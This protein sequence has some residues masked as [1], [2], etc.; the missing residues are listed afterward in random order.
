MIDKKLL[1][2]AVLRSVWH[3]SSSFVKERKRPLLT[4]LRT[5]W[6]IRPP[7]TQCRA[8]YNLGHLFS[9]GRGRGSCR[10]QPDTAQSLNNLALLYHEQERYAEA[11]SLF[12]R[13][14]LGRGIQKHKGVGDV[15]PFSPEFFL[16]LYRSASRYCSSEGASVGLRV[17]AD[18]AFEL[19]SEGC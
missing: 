14:L 17:D 18:E 5:A 6:E 11:E 13:A 10:C 15:K 9:P 2:V 19:V 7:S 3:G 8:S 1:C 16:A 4:S 12:V